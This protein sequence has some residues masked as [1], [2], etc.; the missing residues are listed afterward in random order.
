MDTDR[1]DPDLGRVLA[2]EHAADGVMTEAVDTE[3]H[4][5]AAVTH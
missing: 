5:S 4:H 2:R 1:G 3:A